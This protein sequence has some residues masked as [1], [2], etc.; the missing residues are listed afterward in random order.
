MSY[1]AIIYNGKNSLTDFD[2][3]P[4]SKELPAPT[5]KVI[6]ETVPYMSGVWDFSFHD[7]DV[8]EYEALT[9]KYSFDVIAETKTELNAQKAALLAWVHSRGEQR[10]YDTDISL[11]KY[12]SAYHAQASWS[13]ND[14][15]GLLTVEF[16][17]YPFMKAD[18]V[19]R[20][21]L[22]SESQTITIENEGGRV[23]TPTI[24]V[25][26]KNLLVYPFFET[27][28]TTN[29]LTFTDN[30]DGTVTVNGTATAQTTFMLAQV[31]NRNGRNLYL[32]GCPN[33]GS[34]K[35]YSLI[36]FYLDASNKWQGESYEIGNGLKIDG[37]RFSVGIFIRNGAT[38]E[39]LVFKPQLEE[40][41]FATPFEP[42]VEANATI[43]DGANSHTLGAGTYDGLL[44]L[45]AGANT[46]T[47]KGAGVLYVEY[48]EE[49][50]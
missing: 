10:L 23:I 12:Y 31:Q 40:N 27:T 24:R 17:C 42:Y 46:I 34:G 48:T 36:A 49:T 7:G 15:Q 50:F 25:T 11:T 33:G 5:R 29:G 30:G 14:L 47:A 38:V 9:L 1:G 2:L 20:S 37:N 45:G 28:K 19:T 6:T 39:N 4:A 44:T 22:S 13:E 26:S 41:E 32:S 21:A 3:Y 43:S 8:D 18:K 35:T 16:T